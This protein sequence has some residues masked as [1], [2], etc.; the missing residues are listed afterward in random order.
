[1]NVFSFRGDQAD[2][3]EWRSAEIG[4]LVE[5][6]NVAVAEGNATSWE[7]GRT[8]AGDPQLYVLGPRPEY[9]CILCVSRIGHQ[10]VLEDGQGQILCEHNSLATIG[11]RVWT[12]LCGKKRAFAARIALATCAIRETF[13]EKIEPLL[14]GPAELLTHVAPHLAAL[15]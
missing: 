14:E 9:D 10:Y 11:E 1:M 15:A 4:K 12:A 3:S 7:V 8:E 13:E 2:R 5:T 6:F